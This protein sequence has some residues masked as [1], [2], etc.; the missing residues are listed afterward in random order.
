MVQGLSGTLRSAAMISSLFG[1]LGRAGG[2][3]RGA[4]GGE[5]LISFLVTGGTVSESEVEFSDSSCSESNQY[6]AV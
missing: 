4:E 5:S 1:S 6:F 3:F 2:W